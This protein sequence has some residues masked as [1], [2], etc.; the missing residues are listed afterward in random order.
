MFKFD[1]GPLLQS[2]MIATLK[3]AYNSVFCGLGVLQCETNLQ[4][5]MG[6]ESSDVFRFDLLPL[7]QGQLR[8]AKL[9][10]DYKSLLLLE[11]WGIKPTYTF[12]NFG[13][14]LEFWQKCKMCNLENCNYM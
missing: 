6:W 7:L 12:P 3:N 14:Y 11:A 1:H 9:K 4:E 2:Q 5:I 10:S 8:V 13:H